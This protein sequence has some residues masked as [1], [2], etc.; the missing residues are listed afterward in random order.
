M[1]KERRNRQAHRVDE[2]EEVVMSMLFCGDGT[3]NEIRLRT[4]EEMDTRAAA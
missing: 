2:Q 3:R 1:P 4:A